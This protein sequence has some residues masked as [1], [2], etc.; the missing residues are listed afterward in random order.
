MKRTISIICL[1]ASS[2]FMTVAS[3]F[4]PISP[5]FLQVRLID[6][7]IGQFPVPKSPV[8]PP[9]IGIDGYTL[10]IYGGCAGATL[11][12]ADQDDAVV[13]SVEVADS[14]EEITLPETL[15]GEYELRVLRSNYCFYATIEL[16]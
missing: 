16:Q 2:L 11:Q 14:T 9:S 1:A 6:P 4:N 3:E 15:S 10:Y 5:I 7:T 12:L 13:Y 8:V